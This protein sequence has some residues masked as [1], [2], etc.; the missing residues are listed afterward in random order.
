MKIAERA[1]ILRGFGANEPEISELLA[2][3]QNVFQQADSQNLTEFPLSSEPHLAA[4]EDYAFQAKTKG[5]WEVLKNALVQ[6]RF[7]IQAGISQ[8]ESYRAATLKGIEPDLTSSLTLQQPEALQLNIHKS[9]AGKIPILLT[10][11]RADFVSL[12][13]AITKRNEPVD[14]PD[15]MG[16]CMVAGYNNWDRVHRYRQQWSTDNIDNSALAWSKAFKQLIARKE[17]YQDKFIIL[18][19]GFYS[20]VPPEAL[21]LTEIQWKRLSL[22][23]R[24]EHECTHYFT[25][26]VYNS[27]RNNLL[28]EFIAD[29]RGIVAAT[30]SYNADWFLRF[31]GLESLPHYREG[32]R[33]QNYRGQLSDKA[34]RIL[35]ILVK[36]AAEN[37]ENFD[38]HCVPHLKTNANQT[39]MLM[40]LTSFTLEE[41]A[42]F[43][44][45]DR[46]KKIYH[47]E[48]L[49]SVKAN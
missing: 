40:T 21:G 8:T 30:G 18:S 4:W 2:Y 43:Q 46:L 47:T 13:R 45:V 19:D 1:K 34:F 39:L 35:Q 6:L 23:I 36:S 10:T 20:N 28:D 11:N 9:L 48:T 17:L 14:I 16:A 3:N 49:N 38:R 15:S 31:M 44:A 26:R 25:R 32:G 42:S 41:L 12:V 22:T 33:L 24:L 5:T 37:L 7:P 29:Y 27:M